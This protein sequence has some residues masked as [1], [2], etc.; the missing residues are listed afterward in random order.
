MMRRI[1]TIFLKEAQDNLRDRRSLSAA[2]IF[3]LIGPLVTAGVIRLTTQVQLEQADKPI[4]IALAGGAHAPG[5]ISYLKQHRVNPVVMETGLRDAVWDGD[6]DVALA[7]PQDFSAEF[8]ASRPAAVQL[9][10]DT[11]QNSSRHSI[12][13]IRGL[14]TSYSRQI[15]SLR[16]MARGV[17]PTISAPLAV[18]LVDVA[19]P[20]SLAATVLGMLPFFIMIA[21]FLGGY[22]IVVDSTA[23]ELE[24]R[25]L[26][27]LFIN[28]AS[29]WEF[30]LGKF[31]A[32][33]FFSAAGLVVAL[34]GF[35]VIPHLISTEG[36]G[37]RIRLD[38]LVLAKIFLLVIPL[39]ALATAIGMIVSTLSR[40]FKE[41]QT[42]LSLLMMVP[43]IPGL[44][45]TLA[46]F[47]IK[48]WMMMVPIL[49]E[50]LLINKLIRGEVLSGL[51][52]T[53]C[54]TTTLVAAIISLLIATRLYSGER[55]FVK[56]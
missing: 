7:I 14:L 18:A 25:S 54:V 15:G 31:M 38:A 34:I 50:Q 19:T 52:V 40:G 3:T 20:A 8:R 6:Y 53:I 5:L 32:A 29:R 43:V 48:T 42:M 21:I 41:A 44:L 33:G 39:T 55:I 56:R 27:P 46:P 30:L 49:S 26:E 51:H 23:G 47:K 35:W 17:D 10:A 36:L 13:R 9:I 28:P 16:L 11:S 24:R 22:Y 37:L 1:Q 12:R 4:T 2:L 45:L